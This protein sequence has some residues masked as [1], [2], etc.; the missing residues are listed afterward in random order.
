MELG[1]E[2][3]ADVNRHSLHFKLLFFLNGEQIGNVVKKRKENPCKN[4]TL[5]I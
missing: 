1:D 5:L 3:K 4:V 2:K